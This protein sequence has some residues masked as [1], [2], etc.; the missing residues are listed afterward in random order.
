MHL[1]HFSSS[2]ASRKRGCWFRR[3]GGKR[4]SQWHLFFTA[5]RGW[6]CDARL[7]ISQSPD[8]TGSCEAHWLPLSPSNDPCSLQKFHFPML[9]APDS[10]FC[11][12]LIQSEFS[13]FEKHNTSKSLHVKRLEICWR[14]NGYAVSKMVL[15]KVGTLAYFQKR[16]WLFA[17]SKKFKGC[18]TGNYFPVL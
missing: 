18:T 8:T 14:I 13:Y 5:T 10:L 6:C 9:S 7:E 1:R 4:G 16:D 15:Q 17:D 2:R 11:E 12:R 3:F